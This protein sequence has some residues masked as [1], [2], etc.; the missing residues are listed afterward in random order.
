LNAVKGA[1][2][3]AGEIRILGTAEI[4]PAQPPL[5]RAATALLPLDVT[6]PA[7]GINR[8]SRIVARFLVAVVR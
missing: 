6:R 3:A 4:D 1:E 8:P 5:T 7:E 2:P